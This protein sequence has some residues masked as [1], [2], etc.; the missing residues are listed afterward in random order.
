MRHAASM[1]S[2]KNYDITFSLI[3]GL[4][5]ISVVVGHAAGNGT[6][7]HTFVNQY[8]LAA[9]FFVAGYFIKDKD[10]NKPLWFIWKKIKTLYIPF[11]IVCF[12]VSAIEIIVTHIMSNDMQRIM[13]DCYTVLTWIIKGYWG[14]PLMTSMWFVIGLFFSSI[15][16]IIL[17]RLKKAAFFLSVVIMMVASM[18]M[19]DD[20]SIIRM[21][22]FY[23]PIMFLGHNFREYRAVYDNLQVK[24]H[25]R[26]LAYAT[27]IILSCCI[28]QL[29]SLQLDHLLQEKPYTILLVSLIGSLFMYDCAK[30]CFTPPPVSLKL[31]IS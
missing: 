3:K 25:F 28:G 2:A 24:R 11:V 9:F 14:N 12:L 20:A 8:H 21:S 1:E 19:P 27:L 31:L 5:I 4:A 26:V 10:I 17:A 6:F 18:N 23:V 13:K 22:L 15:F 7:L 16:F 29:G 30:L